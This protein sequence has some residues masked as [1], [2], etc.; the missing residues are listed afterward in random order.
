M[1]AEGLFL[2]G[3]ALLGRGVVGVAVAARVEGLAAAFTGP[4]IDVV[5]AGVS[6]HLLV[7]TR[8]PMAVRVLR[9]LFLVQG[10]SGLGARRA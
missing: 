2:D 4:S 8:P 7:R 6:L 1:H 10:L 3:G 9:I 5:L